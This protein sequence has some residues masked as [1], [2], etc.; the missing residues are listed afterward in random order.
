MPPRALRTNSG[1]PS[2]ATTS[3]QRAYLALPPTS[4]ITQPGFS[5][6]PPDGEAKVTLRESKKALPETP[7]DR[8][9]QSIANYLHEIQM[10]RFHLRH[11][12]QFCLSKPLG[13]EDCNMPGNANAVVAKRWSLAGMPAM[14]EVGE[15]S[16]TCTKT[17]ST[18]FLL[19]EVLRPP[20]PFA[21][22]K[23]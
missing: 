22:C 3:F 21:L 4:T 10:A 13:Q 23:P 8:H 12:Q 5:Q 17:S 16:R 9:G 7:V 2:A 14:A 6:S 11:R 20:E 18:V 15:L 1:L 19:H